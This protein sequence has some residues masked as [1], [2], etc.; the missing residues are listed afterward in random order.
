MEWGEVEG[1]LGDLGGANV[2]L[3]H[4][5]MSIE[6]DGIAAQTNATTR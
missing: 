2:S 3:S 1:M 4:F 6:A 5:L